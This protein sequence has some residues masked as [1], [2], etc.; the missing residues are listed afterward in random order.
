MD[1]IGTIFACLIAFVLGYVIG[2][3]I[4]KRTYKKIQPFWFFQG[5]IRGV[6]ER[7]QKKEEQKDE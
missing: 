7:V 1:Y 5:Y 4:S 6:S 2:R 3:V